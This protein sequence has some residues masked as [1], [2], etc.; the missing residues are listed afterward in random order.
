[1]ELS[2]GVVVKEGNRIKRGPKLQLRNSDVTSAKLRS[3]RPVAADVNGHK[4]TVAEIITSQSPVLRPLQST[5]PIP[6][7]IP[8]PPVHQRMVEI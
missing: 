8:R 6:P 2:P 4:L 5:D 3:L 7:I 1:M